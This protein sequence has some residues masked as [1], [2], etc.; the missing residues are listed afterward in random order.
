MPV[1]L[2]G[3]IA[4]ELGLSHV[5]LSE[6]PE[7]F[8]RLAK[9]VFGQPRP[10]WLPRICRKAV[11]LGRFIWKDRLYN[12]R[13]ALMEAL[14]SKL[15]MFGGPNPLASSSHQVKVFVTAVEC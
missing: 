5:S 6:A 14:G 15:V 11:D 12:T 9:A 10:Q 2:G 7:R 1:M 4:M 8:H 3:I 13:P